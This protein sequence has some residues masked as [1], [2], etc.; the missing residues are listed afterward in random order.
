MTLYI[1]TNLYNGLNLRASPSPSATV[2]GNMSFATVCELVEDTGTNWKKVRAPLGGTQ[3]VGFASD[4][5]L[6]EVKSD[7]IVRLL[8]SI[9]HY[10]TLFDRGV[11]RE[12]V[13]PFKNEVLKMWDDLGGGRP[14]GNDTSHPKWPWSAAGMSAFIRRASGYTG[15]KFA[16][17]HSIYIHDSIV[18]MK[19]GQTAP[20][21]GF[22]INEKK[23]EVGDLIAQWR[24][25]QRTY[26]FAAANDSFNSH[27]DVVCQ[28]I[29][30]TVRA[31]GANV[32]TDTVGVKVYH[33][34]PQGFLAGARNEIA[35]LKN[36]AQ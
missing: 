30:G 26:D 13:L 3:T 22:R 29:N 32:P 11:G 27:T 6:T 7:G 28:I 12:N 2:L 25:T 23:P 4:L 15:F 21:W 8:A 33:L 20:F 35:I 14:P 19:A 17:G 5:Y 24:I 16:A 1:V 31:I 10:W 34:T 9:M 36:M 18:K